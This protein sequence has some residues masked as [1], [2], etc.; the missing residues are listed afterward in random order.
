MR[1]YKQ[2]KKALS[3][4]DLDAFLELIWSEDELYQ[5]DKKGRHRIMWGRLA[6]G[7]CEA[8]QGA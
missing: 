7:P 5:A 8:A 1:P 2:A 4:R 6:Q 3:R